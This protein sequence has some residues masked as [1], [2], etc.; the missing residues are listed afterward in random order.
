VIVVVWSEGEGIRQE[1]RLGV[2]TVWSHWF[3]SEFRKLRM[4]MNVEIPRRLR[5]LSVPDSKHLW[6]RKHRQR[7]E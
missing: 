5:G 1:D 7:K 2:R 6:S 3:L 4:N